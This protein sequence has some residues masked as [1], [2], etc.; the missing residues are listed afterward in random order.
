MNPAR[1]PVARRR[2]LLPGQ[3]DAFRLKAPFPEYERQ[4]P[5]RFAASGAPV[6][7][8]AMKGRACPSVPAVRL[9]SAPPKTKAREEAASRA[10]SVRWAGVRPGLSPS[11][12]AF[13]PLASICAHRTPRLCAAREP[14]TNHSSPRVLGVKKAAL[15]KENDPLT[16]ALGEAGMHSSASAGGDEHIAM[17]DGID[18][19]LLPSQDRHARTQVPSRSFRTGVRAGQEPFCPG[20]PATPASFAAP[21]RPPRRSC[22]RRSAERRLPGAPARSLRRCFRWSARRLPAARAGPERAS[23]R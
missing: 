22:R 10:L 7:H 3:T 14:C 12:C 8:Q 18:G 16:W 6:C 5:R 19:S 9:A 11:Q 1:V 13:P 4:R 17:P 20:F 23:C 21:S 15:A 2:A